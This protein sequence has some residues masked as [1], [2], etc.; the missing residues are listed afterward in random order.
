VDFVIEFDDGSVLAFEV[1]TGER[2]RGGD[3]KGLRK[4]REALGNRFL[5]GVAFSM[6]S[7]SFTLEDRVHVLPLDR[8]WRSVPPPAVPRPARR[9]RAK[10][11]P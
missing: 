10:R 11:T 2:L 8:L 3:L 1:K 4:L 7:R 6:G 9:P 5:A